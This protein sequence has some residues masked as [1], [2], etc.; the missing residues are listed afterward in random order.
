MTL[1]KFFKINKL[2]LALWGFCCLSSITPVKAQEIAVENSVS[3]YDS[4]LIEYMLFD[5]LLL[6]ELSADS[7]SFLQLLDDLM[8]EKYLKSSFSIRIGYTGEV[9]NAGRTIGINQYGYNT[10]VSYYHKSGVFADVSGYWNSDQIPNYN[11]TITDLGYM[12]NFTANWSYWASY[13]HYFFTVPEDETI[14]YPFTNAI[15]TS[16]NYYIKKIGLGLD[17][18][19][20]FGAETAHR[21]RVNSGYN[22]SKSNWW[23]FDRV[24]IN[25]NLSMLMGNANVITWVI[26]NNQTIELVKQMG[27]QKFRDL[28]NTD[29]TESYPV[30]KNAFGIMNY[31]LFLPLSFSIKKATLMVNYTLNMPVALPGEVLDTSLNNYVSAT[32][33][34][35]F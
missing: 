33:M 3:T 27:L 35:T 1:H 4:L 13:S 18:S 20:T 15:N 31:S 29:T 19:F 30:D 24:G 10:G 9:S 11:A 25:P 22:F 34:Y 8:E 28:Q 21:I 26:D 5:S 12:G 23:I 14:V 7:T 32:L 6:N 2:T 17:Y 16:S